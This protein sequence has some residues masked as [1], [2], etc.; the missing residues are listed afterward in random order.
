MW[1]CLLASIIYLYKFTCFAVMWEK[2]RVSYPR[3]PVIVA[4]RSEHP[5]MS[6]C[7]LH[8]QLIVNVEKVKIVT[9]ASYFLNGMQEQIHIH[10]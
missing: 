6:I 1:S 8:Y 5:F 9:F 10:M 2:G 3:V 4:G 7:D